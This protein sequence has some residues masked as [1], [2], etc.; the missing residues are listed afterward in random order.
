MCCKGC[1]FYLILEACENRQSQCFANLV[2]G[3]CESGIT[4]YCIIN[5][6]SQTRHHYGHDI[7][8]DLVNEPSLNWHCDGVNVSHEELNTLFAFA[9]REE[10]TSSSVCSN[11]ESYIFTDATNVEIGASSVIIHTQQVGA[12]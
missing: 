4:K 9:S 5:D 10:C 7:I 1:K 8:H 6:V 12:N 3:F 2:E 11:D